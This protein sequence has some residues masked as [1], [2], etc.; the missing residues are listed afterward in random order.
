MKSLLPLKITASIALIAL[1]L[2]ALAHKAIDAQAAVSIIGAL[3]TFAVGLVTHTEIPSDEWE[4]RKA[5]QPREPGA[6]PPKL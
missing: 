6:G 4:K 2:V 3:F 5:E 1:A